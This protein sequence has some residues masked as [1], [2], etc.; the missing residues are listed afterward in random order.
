MVQKKKLKYTKVFLVYNYTYTMSNSTS[1][2]D[3][4]N[5]LHSEKPTHPVINILKQE[6]K[7][8][9]LAKDPKFYKQIRKPKK[10]KHYRMS[11][12][13]VLDDLKNEIPHLSLSD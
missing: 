9:K 10:T 12:L 3:N 13:G 7:Q 6:E 2:Q 8:A 4:N 11:N 5:I 1:D